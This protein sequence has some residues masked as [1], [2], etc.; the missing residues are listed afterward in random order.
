MRP[1][2]VA[3]DRRRVLLGSLAGENPSEVDRRAKLKMQRFDKWRALGTR[4]L[5][6]FDF[7]R[8]GQDGRG[9]A[10]TRG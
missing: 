1:F 7:Q 4:A 6:L 8:R 5:L 10:D 2:T 9:G 3:A